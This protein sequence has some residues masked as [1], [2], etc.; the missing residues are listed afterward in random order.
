MCLKAA[1]RCFYYLINIILA[2]RMLLLDMNFQFHAVVFSKITN[3]TIQKI[4][5][6]NVSVHF[7]VYY[8]YHTQDKHPFYF[9]TV[10]TSQ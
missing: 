10:M 7:D 1:E 9:Y 2:K 3:W 5:S 8:I 6:L 4:T